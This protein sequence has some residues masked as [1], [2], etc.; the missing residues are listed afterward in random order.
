MPP[1]DEIMESLAAEAEEAGYRGNMRDLYATIRNLSGKY[2]KPERLVKDKDGQSISDLEGQKRRWVKHHLTSSS[3][4]L[5]RQ[6][7]SQQ[8]FTH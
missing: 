2:R 4:D 8:R 1:A 3:T 6:T 5:T 7:N